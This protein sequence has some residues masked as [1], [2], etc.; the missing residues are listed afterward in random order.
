MK[1][2]LTLFPQDFLANHSVSQGSKKAR[3]MTVISGQ[4]CLGSLRKS[5]PLFSLVKM[6]LES[7]RWHSTRCSLNWKTKDTPAK[8]LLF[9]LAPS[10]PSTE[11]TEFGLLLTPTQMQR[12]EDPIDFRARQDARGYKNRTKYNSLTIQVVYH[13]TFLPTP[14]TTD[15]DDRHGG[16]KSNERSTIR[17]R[18]LLQGEQT[19]SSLGSQ[20][21]RCSGIGFTSNTKHDGFPSSEIQRETRNNAREG[22]EREIELLEPERSGSSPPNQSRRF[23]RITYPI[24]Q[25][26]ICRGDDGISFRLDDGRLISSKKRNMALKQLGNSVVPQVVYEIF[27][28][29]SSFIKEND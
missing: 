27:K 24:S 9:Q 21:S 14:R 6:F 28:I 8:R 10:M 7:Y 17:E 15:T 11:E 29:I 18:E 1:E 2:Q 16:G 20:T 23:Q 13:P 5:N 19:G 4:K 25:P 22:E 12:S 26:T 3:K